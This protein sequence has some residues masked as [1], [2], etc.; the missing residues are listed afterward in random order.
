VIE[1]IISYTKDWGVHHIDFTGLYSAQERNFFG[2]AI[3]ATSFINDE[4]SFNNLGAG[5]NISAGPIPGI[6]NYTGSYKDRYGLVSQMGRINY[7]YD[8]RY[9]LTLTARRDGSSVMGSNTSK[10]GTFPSAAFAWNINNEGFMR[11]NKLFDNL[12]LRTSYGKTGNEAIGVY[13][14]ITTT[15]TVRFPFTGVS[16]IGVLASN[17]GNSNLHWETSKVLNF[18]LDFG[19][20]KNRISGTIDFYSTR[21]EDLILRRNIPI[22]TGYPNVLDNLGKTKNTGIEIMLNTENIVTKNFRWQSVINFS[23]NKNRIVEI[24][25]DGKDDLG[26]RWFIGQPIN[27]VYDYELIGVWQV[28]EDPSQ[29]DPGARPGDLKFADINN[30]KSI[31][32]D[33]RKIL[34]TT[35]PKWIGGMINT[36]HYRD[37][38][39]SIFVQTFQGAIKNNTTLT[40]ADEGWR[41]NLPKEAGYWTEQNR[42]NSRPSFRYTNSRG[43]N[44]PSDNSY[45]RIKDVTLSYTAPQKVLNKLKVGSLTFYASGRNLYTFTN[46]I[47][48]D[49]EHNYSFRGVGEWTTN[50]PITRS[51]V[52][53]VNLSPR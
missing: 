46:W 52:F 17:L 21:T 19:I 32:P 29:Q 1:N 50:Y 25:G 9:L 10:Y 35:S 5:S 27:V 18:G 15:G 41:M 28:G 30:S 49:P 8:S 33:D 40:Y 20:L 34:G 24:Y 7:S 39:L 48:W 6:P 14:T 13:G 2:E 36:F 45:T 53:G 37:F 11:N 22:I 38:H 51:I 12:K 44:Y 3:N 23:S 47:G 4:L 16:T 42:S 31:T 43:Y 26:N